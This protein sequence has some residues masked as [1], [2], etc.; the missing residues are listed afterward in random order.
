MV[1]KK[2]AIYLEHS[3]MNFLE[4][5]C[6]FLVFRFKLDFLINTLKN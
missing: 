3:Q 1:V 6:L 4:F 2:Y 5:K